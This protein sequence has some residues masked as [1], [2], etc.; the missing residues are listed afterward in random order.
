MNLS[1]IIPHLN[2]RRAE[3]LPAIVAKLETAIASGIVPNTLMT[4]AKW[5]INSVA[6][7]ATEAFLSSGPRTEEHHMSVWWRAAYD[8]DAFVSG[9]INIPTAIKRT[10][11]IA[12]LK[13]YNEFLNV[14]M[15]LH[16]MLQAAKPLIVKRGDARM[17]VA[18]K[19]A[20]QI[21]K[22]ARQMTCQ[23]CGRAHL[24]NTGLLA[25]HGY[26]HPGF[27][28]QTASCIGARQLPFEVARDRLGQH[29]INMTEQKGR[30]IANR[31]GIE[32]ET[33]GFDVEYTGN[34][35]DNKGR[36]KSV[37]VEVTRE[38]WDAVKSEHDSMFSRHGRNPSFN[39][40]KERELNSCNRQIK[41][42]G[43]YIEFQQAR[44]D[45]WKQT[46]SGFDKT[47]ETWTKL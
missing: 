26:T 12:A 16:T 4:D 34:E 8:A 47:T 38:T 43:E 23:C 13:E 32:L 6:H 11:K 31:D 27:G 7:D 9:A 19:T 20:E 40:M 15:P 25:H 24:A 10:A 45:G 1:A 33:T 18:P 37:R 3:Q 39:E 35:K 30:M 29:I 5:I 21:A 46:H 42:I 17:P 41:S 28:W 14:L 36:R 22:E 2:E 44:Y